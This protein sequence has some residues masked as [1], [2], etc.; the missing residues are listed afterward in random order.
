[1]F[2]IKGSDRSIIVP[3]LYRNVILIWNFFIANYTVP[4][5]D[6]CNKIYVNKIGIVCVLCLLIKAVYLCNIVNWPVC[7]VWFS[8]MHDVC[9]GHLRASY[10]PTTHATR[11]QQQI[12]NTL[13]SVN[14]KNKL[15]VSLSETGVLLLH[16][17]PL[18]P[19]FNILLTSIQVL[20][21]NFEHLTTW[22][23]ICL[24]CCLYKGINFAYLFHMLI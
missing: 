9:V 13:S 2:M 23:S 11:S 4:I 17:M 15:K 3:I 20:N 10:A 22:S 18:F 6:I 14:G 1:M 24:P 21:K 7:F 8:L 16:L 5:I 12:T 19:I